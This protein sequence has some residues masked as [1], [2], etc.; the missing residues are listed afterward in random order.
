MLPSGNVQQLN[1]L[2]LCLFGIP[3]LTGAI[4]VVQRH[5][6]ARAGEGIIYDLRREMYDHL[7]KMSMR[8]FT[9]TKSGEIVS[10][11]N[12]DV[13]GAQGAITG[14]IPDIVTN[15]VTLVSTLAIMITIEW[16][17]ALLA[18]VVFP[19]FLLPARHVARILRRI[20][21]KAMEY[22]AEM[23]SQ[24]AE[25]LSVNGA[26]LV[27]TFGR[28]QKEMDSFR[29]IS[30]NVRDM[31]I[32]RAQVSQ[33]FF[34]GMGIVGAIGTAMIYWSGG[35]MVMNDVITVGTIVAFVAYL[36]RLY[37]PISSLTNVQVEFASSMVSFE[38]VFEYLDIPVE[39][40]DRPDAEQLTQVNGQIRFDHV[41]FQYALGESGRRRCRRRC[42]RHTMA[43]GRASARMRRVGLFK[44]CRSLSN[45]VSLWRWWD[46][47]APAKR[48]SA[49]CCRV[50]MTRRAAL[51]RSMAT[52]CA[53]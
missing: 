32:K 14:T 21:R 4:G 38:R 19:L 46:P 16:R 6:G 53:L 12:S 1:L 51:S 23:S 27:K 36:S 20:R 18:V 45:P 41:Y 43:M 25:T 13:V 3:L 37:G 42:A 52:T 33:L 28:Q 10:R 17:L 48:P 30:A 44:M 47:A 2:A 39:I 22:N 11:F 49:T 15:V 24:I 34:L 35:Y 5:Y 9:H 26:L 7:Q 40:Q 29:R 31:G 8:F 50:S